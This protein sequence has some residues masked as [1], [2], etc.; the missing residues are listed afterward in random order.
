MCSSF[1]LYSFSCLS[2][3]LL[4]SLSLNVSA[5]S[6]ETAENR[7]E[8]SL[9]ALPLSLQ[10]FSLLNTENKTLNAILKCLSLNSLQM[11]SCRSLRFF[12]MEEKTLQKGKWI[13]PSAWTVTTLSSQG[14]EPLISSLFTVGQ[15]LPFR[16]ICLSACVCERARCLQV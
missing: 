10:A 8:I 1:S 14:G 5:I 7:G 13:E 16:S 12:L 15:I 9:R 4:L 11:S 6:G 3:S 2:Y